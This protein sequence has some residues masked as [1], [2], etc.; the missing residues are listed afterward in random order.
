VVETSKSQPGEALL[1]SALR[2]GDERA[3]TELVQR[4]HAYL[5]RVALVFVRSPA[6]AEEVAQETWLV[7]LEGIG[8][9]EGRSSVRSWLFGI[10]V[11][12]ARTRGE[13]EARTAP[14]SSLESEDEDA[15]AVDPSRFLPDDHPRWPGHWAAPPEQWPEE[16]LLQQETLR[17][18]RSAIEALPPAQRKVIV[19]RDVEGC[20]AEEVCEAL[21]ISDGN[22]RILLHRARSKVRA[23]LEQHL[24]GPR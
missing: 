3:F 24:V 9:F 4:H 1:V 17:L 2:A 14:L 6:V 11:N 19:L 5:V 7:A 10:A 22:Q 8:K 20:S 16:R 12:R 13:R 18:M 21:K 15:P 23:A